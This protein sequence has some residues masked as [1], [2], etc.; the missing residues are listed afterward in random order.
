MIRFV[1][2]LCFLQFTFSQRIVKCPSEEKWITVKSNKSEKTLLFD[3]SDCFQNA[4]LNTTLE[5]SIINNGYS[6]LIVDAN[7]RGK[8]KKGNDGRF[9]I[10]RNSQKNCQMEN[11]F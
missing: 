2:I 9:I 7:Y 3:F 4:S 8:D 1:F 11:C 10:N 6:S 5:F